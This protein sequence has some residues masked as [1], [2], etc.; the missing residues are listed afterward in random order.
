M[1]KMPEWKRILLRSLRRRLRLF[2]NAQK[3]VRELWV[4]KRF[5]RAAKIRYRAAEVTQGDEPDDVRFRDAHFQVKEI[6]DSGRR[7]TDEIKALIETVIKAK[8]RSELLTPW[9][10]TNISF[11]DVASVCYEYADKLVLEAKYGIREQ[12]GIDL[13]FY[14]NWANHCV[15]EPLDVPA[16]AIGFRSL[17]IVSNEYSVVAS[18]N[19]TAPAFLRQRAGQV[20]ARI[21]R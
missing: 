14:F 8:D 11:S 17:S 20:F 2:S 21:E 16:K 7:R 4:A 18:A 13:L 15:D 1:T 19:D 5:L 9:H 12:A 10:L 6:F 3:P